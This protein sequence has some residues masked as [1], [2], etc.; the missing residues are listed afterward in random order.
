MLQVPADVH[1]IVAA[2]NPDTIASII[3]DKAEELLPEAIVVA[4]HGKRG[5]QVTSAS[6]MHW[7][8]AARLSVTHSMSGHD[9]AGGKGVIHAICTAPGLLAGAD[10][11]WS[12]QQSC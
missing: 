5:L 12:V 3:L 2:D 8:V 11:Y 4:S 7:L 10:C 9:L 6:V 1:L